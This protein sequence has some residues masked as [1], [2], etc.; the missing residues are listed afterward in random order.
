MTE[1]DCF[2]CHGEGGKIVNGYWEICFGCLGR[3][4]DV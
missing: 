4:I 3:G 1:G 2:I